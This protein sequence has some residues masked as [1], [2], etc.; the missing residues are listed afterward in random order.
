MVS[1][2]DLSVVIPAFNERH[3]LPATVADIEQVLAPAGGAYEIIVSDDGST[4]GTEQLVAELAAVTPG[5]RLVRSV[6]NRGKG[7][8]V[9]IG[10]QAATGARVLFC[11]ADG[12][13]PMRELARLDRALMDG[14]DIVV[15]SRALAAPDI[16]RA[17]KLHRRVMGRIY[18]LVFT[19]RLAP[20]IRDTQCGF[21][22]FTAAAAQAVAERLHATGFG[23]DIEIFVIARRL[24]L[25][26]AE[27]PVSW[28]DQPGSKV[29]LVRD[30]MRM[31][32]DV[33]AVARRD[34][35]GIYDP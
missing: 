28:H 16:T 27:V 25:T 13:T 31:A 14:A 6:T 10:I 12:A 24:G 29:R 7:H 26:V 18:S 2:P 19:A 23:F 1:S 32:R 15:G 20:G 17:T 9:K 8:A 35:A 33:V 34:R 5:L 21:K 30:S 4:D 22:L 11:D 3:R